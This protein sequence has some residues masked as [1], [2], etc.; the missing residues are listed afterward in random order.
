MQLRNRG[1]PPETKPKTGE[2]LWLV[3]YADAWLKLEARPRNLILHAESAPP[4][5]KA[6]LSY[7]NFK[8]LAIASRQ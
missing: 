6:P 3:G 1:F 7:G 4:L 8:P 5:I 2:P